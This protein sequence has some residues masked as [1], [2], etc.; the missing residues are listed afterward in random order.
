MKNFCHSKS[1]GNIHFDLNVFPYYLSTSRLL[2]KELFEEENFLKKIVFIFCDSY[3]NLGFK[4]SSL[5]MLK[6]VEQT[7]M[8]N[9]SL[10]IGHRQHE[11]LKMFESFRLQ[12]PERAMSVMAIIKISL[13]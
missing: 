2:K 6:I 9:M 4:K 13:S 5:F 7:K 10:F 11:Q 1:L 3:K 8:I 12:T